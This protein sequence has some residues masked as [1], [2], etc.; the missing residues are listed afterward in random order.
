[1]IKG[2][3][4]DTPTFIQPLATDQCAIFYLDPIHQ[5]VTKG[6]PTRSTSTVV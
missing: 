3:A 5:P 1:M 6:D 4:L 2:D